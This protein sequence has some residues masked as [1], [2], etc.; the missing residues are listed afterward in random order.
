[1]SGLCSRKKNIPFYAPS[2]GAPFVGAFQNRVRLG[3]LTDKNCKN[4]TAHKKTQYEITEQNTKWLDK[5]G[6]VGKTVGV[7]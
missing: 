2:P 4:T 6:A 7:L 1:M 5:I 3:Y